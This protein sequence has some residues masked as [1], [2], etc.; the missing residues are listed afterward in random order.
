M[1]YL[2]ILSFIIS[3]TAF[4]QINITKNT[5]W[6]MNSQQAVHSFLMK[7]NYQCKVDTLYVRPNQYWQTSVSGNIFKMKLLSV[8]GVGNYRRTFWQCTYMQS[9]D[10]I[11]LPYTNFG[12]SDMVGNI[13]EPSDSLR[14]GGIANFSFDTVDSQILVF[15]FKIDG[16]GTNS[17]IKLRIIKREI[18]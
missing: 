12:E 7:W 1:R 10:S 16:E 6:N 15:P 3:I 17:R 13:P 11:Y 8:S 4:A 14:Q 9:I 2:L 18:P 5:S